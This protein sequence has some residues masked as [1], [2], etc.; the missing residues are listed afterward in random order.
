MRKIVVRIK[1][2]EEENA[3]QASIIDLVKVAAIPDLICFHPANGEKRAINTARKLKDIGVLAGVTDLVFTH[4]LTGRTHYME[5]KT[6]NGSLTKD[7]RKFRDKCKANNIPWALVRSRDQAQDVLT[8]WE[9]LRV[10][11][12]EK[13][14]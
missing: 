10:R 5:V 1:R 7:Q 13:A 4:P 11:K 14:A 8:D 12:R 6:E 9:M 2:R 3:I